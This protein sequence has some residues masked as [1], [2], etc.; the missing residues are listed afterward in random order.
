MICEIM[1][2]SRQGKPGYKNVGQEIRGPGGQ[3][4]W[5][6]PERRLT[7]AN[8]GLWPHSWRTVGEGKQAPS[9]V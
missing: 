7:L 1:M 4:Q 5:S 2:E 3:E 9:R 8:E 6:W